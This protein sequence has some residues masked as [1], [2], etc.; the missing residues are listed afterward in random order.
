[1]ALKKQQGIALP[2]SLIFLLL[3]AL[4]GLSIMKISLISIKTAHNE[5]TSMKSF[6]QAELALRIGEK[7]VMTLSDNN[8]YTDFSDA[9]DYLYVFSSR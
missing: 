8:P 7:E 5:E 9:N 3:L 6:N 2:I 4:I 1:M